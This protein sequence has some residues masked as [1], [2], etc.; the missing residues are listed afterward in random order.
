MTELQRRKI[1]LADGKISKAEYTE[2]KLNWQKTTDDCGKHEIS[3][4][5][6]NL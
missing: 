3:K 4:E 2:W 5:W 6:R 1:D